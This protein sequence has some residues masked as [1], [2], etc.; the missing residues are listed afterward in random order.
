MTAVRLF[1]L[2]C[3]GALAGCVLFIDTPSTFDSACRFAGDTIEACGKC[4][5]ASCRAQVDACCRDGSCRPL[6]D[7][8]DQCATSSSPTSS[9]GCAKLQTTPTSSTA[10]TTLQDCIRA[11]CAGSCKGSATADGGKPAPPSPVENGATSCSSYEPTSCSC[12]TIGAGLGNDTICNQESVGGGICCLDSSGSGAGHQSCRCTRFSCNT[13]SDGSCQC[14]ASGLSGTATTC[15]GDYC[16]VVD[17]TQSCY[18]GTKPCRAT[19][20]T[21]VQSC[22]PSAVGCASGRTLVSSCSP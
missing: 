7:S 2:A 6:L 22:T 21:R 19:G 10:G 15:D 20:E 12:I 4:V 1:A 18:C 13:S 3:L 11:R 14:Q 8:L 5:A 16:C 17:S 9:T